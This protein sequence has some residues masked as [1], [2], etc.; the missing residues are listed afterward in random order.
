[1]RGSG[2]RHHCL[3]GNQRFRA[4]RCPAGTYQAVAVGEHHSCAVAVDGTI[5][6]WGANDLGQA[7]APVGT[8]QALAAGN[9]HNC[10]IA[11]DDTIVCWGSDSQGMTDAPAGTYQAVAAGGLHSCAI[12]ADHTVVCWGWNPAFATVPSGTF[13]ALTAGGLHSCAVAVDDTIACW[14]P[15]EGMGPTPEGTYK[16]V[17]TG[18]LHSCAIATNDTVVCWGYNEFGQADAPSGTYRDVAAGEGY[19]CAIATDGTIVCWGAIAPPG[20]HTTRSDG[21]PELEPASQPESELE[22]VSQPESD[23][24]PVSQPESEP[25]PATDRGS[26]PD[27]PG[28]GVTVVAGRAVWSQGYFQAALLG[29]LL[30]E[31]GYNVTDPAQLEL[32]PDVAYT[33]MAQGRMDYWPNSWYPGHN[34]WLDREMPDGSTVRD[35]VSVVGEH[36]YR[37][38]QGF[39]IDKSFAD[40]YGVYTMDDLNSSPDALA[41]FDATDPVPGNGKAEFYGCAPTWDCHGVIDNMIAFSGWDNLAQVSGGYEAMF[42]QAVK[43]VNEGVPTVIFTWTPSE[44]ITRLRPGADVYW[45]G[46]A[47]ILDD[48]NPTGVEDGEEHDQRR[49]DGTGGYVSINADRCPSATEEPDGECPVGWFAASI[50]VTA[51]NDFLAA[52]PAAEALFE[53]VSL[54][55]F[56]VSLAD[57][58]RH[59][60]GVRPADLAA[61]WIAD[62]RALVD[63]WLAAA[64]AA[65]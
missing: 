43:N 35:H 18:G 53:A 15:A 47:N 22:L 25:E 64:R 63:Q 44:Y 20:V 12:A 58:A 23:L 48:S 3:L 61:Q 32:G 57:Q 11:A 9:V 39:L 26:D 37:A 50:Q 4:G 6:C 56:D 33:A 41:S 55:S 62:N 16:A 38:V 1:M 19:T 42:A 31:L 28:E 34:Q 7:D 8:Y 24:E 49:P 14:G 59:E 46:V 5:V 40:D 30:G 54:T 51:N 2:R 60:Q 17:A 65:S 21:Q 10:A 45:L 52:N 29:Q 13:R 27:R 36:L